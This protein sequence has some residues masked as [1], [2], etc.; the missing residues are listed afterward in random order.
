MKKGLSN[1][2]ETTLFHIKLSRKGLIGLSP[3]PKTI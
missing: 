2:G 3:V 1:P